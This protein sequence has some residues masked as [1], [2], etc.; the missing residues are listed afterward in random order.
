MIYFYDLLLWLIF[1][2]KII[3]N[4]FHIL[5]FHLHYQTHRVHTD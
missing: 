5:F 2:Y 3:I 1:L 4:L